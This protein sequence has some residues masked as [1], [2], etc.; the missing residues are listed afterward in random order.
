MRVPLSYVAPLSPEPMNELVQGDVALELLD[1][2]VVSL[3]AVAPLVH[4]RMEHV[5][6]SVR[7]PVARV[8]AV[9]PASA[10][11]ESKS[12]VAD[13]VGVC[14]SVILVPAMVLNSVVEGSMVT[15]R[16]GA[17]AAVGVSVDA[18]DGGKSR[19]R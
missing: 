5:A 15:I 11:L 4:N 2:V 13:A 3:R 9:A 1:V 17:G 10:E 8:A 18:G 19:W 7:G 14:D 6:Q 16:A 12:V